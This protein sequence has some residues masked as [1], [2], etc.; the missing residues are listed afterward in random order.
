MRLTWCRVLCEQDHAL[1]RQN[2]LLGAFTRNLY[3]RGDKTLTQPTLL[4]NPT[5][6][7]QLTLHW[8]FIRT[9]PQRSFP[10]SELNKWHH[11][12]QLC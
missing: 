1:H 4:M 6:A 11:E 7:R 2:G 8:T 9:A 12:K 5:L 3:T 10:L